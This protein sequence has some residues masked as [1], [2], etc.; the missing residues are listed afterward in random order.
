MMVA[1]DRKDIDPSVWH[2]QG[3]VIRAAAQDP[4]VERIFANAAIKKALCREAG[5]DRAWLHKVRPYWGHD[6]HFHVRLACPSDSPE[7]KIQ[8]P[9][10]SA[11]DG[12]NELDWWFRDS[13]LHPK[14]SPTPAKPR[15]PMTLAA[16][17]PACR[18][19]VMA[20]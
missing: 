5:S 16:L 4:E 18:D 17:P 13:V 11:G 20:P 19:V 7:C 6:Y 10:P 14:P 3:A 15:T 9:I 8:A 12:C 2:R 1:P